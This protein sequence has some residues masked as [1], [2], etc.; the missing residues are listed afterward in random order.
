MTATIVF[1]LIA[2]IASVAALTVICRLA[3]AVADQRAEDEA[4]TADAAL[5]HELERLAA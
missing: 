2:S 3:Y 5:P 1:N 4:A